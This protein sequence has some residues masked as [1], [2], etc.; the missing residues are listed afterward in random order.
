MGVRAVSKI[1][2]ANA[3]A[4]NGFGMHQIEWVELDTRQ[5]QQ[6]FLHLQMKFY[7]LYMFVILQCLG[8]TK[9][10]ICMHFSKQYGIQV[11]DVS[12]CMWML[13]KCLRLI[14][15]SFLEFNIVRRAVEHRRNLHFHV[16]G[17]KIIMP[18]NTEIWSFTGFY[19]SDLMLLGAPCFT[20][21]FPILCKICSLLT[22]THS[23]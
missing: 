4:R 10:T 14:Q 6:F 11:C 2:Y 15:I 22:H 3:Y 17:F 8:R 21:C 23:L 12:Y 20:A 19:L 1:E 18:A 9:D 7:M 5:L 13:D 16:D